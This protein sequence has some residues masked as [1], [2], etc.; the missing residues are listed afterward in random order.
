M[1]L[2]SETTINGTLHRV[3][4]AWHVLDNLW[5]PFIV[6]YDAPKFG[7]AREYG[8]YAAPK[9]GRR[10]F[11]PDL[12]ESDWPPPNTI[13]VTDMITD[14]T[15]ANAVTVFEGTLHLDSYNEQGVAYTAYGAEHDTVITDEVFNDTLVNVFTWA[16][17]AS[18]LNLTL[19]STA[20]R[21]PSPDVSYTADGEQVLVD[22]LSD[23]AAFFT[24]GFYIENGTLYLIDMLA[25]NGTS[26][27]DEFEFFRGA[28][29]QGPNPYSEIKTTDYNVTGSFKYG[30]E[31]NVSPVCHNTQSNI[32]AALG[33][34]KTIVDQDRYR[35]RLIPESD[36]L[37]VI[38]QG[39]T[40]TNESLQS[41]T[42]TSIRITDYAP[43][44]DQL[45]I[46]I[47]GF[48]SSS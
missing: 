37:P 18:R 29:Y 8:G 27:F 11:S 7:L 32:E 34:I 16:V 13:S 39:L 15:E 14:D 21:S 6:Q 35:F 2:L 30:T 41:S 46:I 22:V 47:E 23:I 43:D 9:W 5:E 25:D 33:D 19:D 38:G 44:I 4:D 3:S 45:A 17:D 24:H 26:T 20:A 12:F 48:G 28:E 40:V 36:Q 10:E 31:L 1:D 42:T